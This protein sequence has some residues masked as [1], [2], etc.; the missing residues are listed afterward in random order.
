[1]L[2]LPEA[3]FDKLAMSRRTDFAQALTLRAR[4][5]ECGY[6]SPVWFS[7]TR[8]T[9]PRGRNYARQQAARHVIRPMKQ[10][11]QAQT[12]AATCPRPCSCS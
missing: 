3:W 11:R 4:A 12:R 5:P 8:E 10:F 2:P 9:M 7:T 1:M 6:E